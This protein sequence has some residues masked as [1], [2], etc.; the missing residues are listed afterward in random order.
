M[1]TKTAPEMCRAQ[2][3]RIIEQGIELDSSLFTPFKLDSISVLERQLQ[4]LR[5]QTGRDYVV[6]PVGQSYGG[7]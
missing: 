1:M 2:H 5:E 3:A 4:E 6:V 7:A